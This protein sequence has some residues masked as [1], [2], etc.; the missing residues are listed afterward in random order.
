MQGA[1]V[2]ALDQDQLDTLRSNLDSKSVSSSLLGTEAKGGPTVVEFVVGEG[3]V[4]DF[5]GALFD[6]LGEVKAV[7][8]VNNIVSIGRHRILV[9]EIVMP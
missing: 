8:V 1:K 9:V 5:S 3:Q 7:D 6:T 2:V 4:E